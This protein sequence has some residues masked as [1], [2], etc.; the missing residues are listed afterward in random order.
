MSS[1]V[2]GMAVLQRERVVGTL[3]KK[4]IRRCQS[5]GETRMLRKDVYSW[6]CQ[7]NGKSVLRVPVN[8]DKG[9]FLMNGWECQSCGLP[10]KAVGE[11]MN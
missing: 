1:Q 8:G 7:G 2:Y 11:G 6:D 5:D 9:L 4:L 3:I 10:V